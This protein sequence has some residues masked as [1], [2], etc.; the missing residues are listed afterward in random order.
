M[1]WMRFC[2]AGMLVWLVSLSTSVTC[3]ADRPHILWLTAEDMSPTLGCWGDSFADTPNLDKFAE[4]SVTYTHA[5]ATAP[6]CSPARSCLITGV[7]ASSLGTQNLRSAFPLPAAISGF[8][9]HLRKLGYYT[10]NNVKTDYN[11]RDEAELIRACWDES[12]PQAH[13]RKRPGDAPFFSIFNDMTTHQSRSMVWTREHFEQD[14]QSQLQ[15]GRVHDPGRVPLPPYYPDTPVVRRTLARFYDC[16]SV[17]D[18]NVGQRL[19]ELEE[20]G[21]ADETIVFFY[22]D[23]GSGMPRHKRLLLDS[24]MHVP[25]MIRFPKKYQHLAPAAAGEKINRLVSFVDFAPT[26]LSLLGIEPPKHMQ[27]TPFL[28]RFSGRERAYVFGARDRVDEAYD[29]AR[30]ARDHRYLYIRNYLPHESYNQPSAYSDLGE[31]RDDITRLAK[32]GELTGAQWHYACPRRAMEELYDTQNDPQNLVNLASSTEHRDILARMREAQRKWSLKTR[33]LGFAPEIDVQA[34]SQ[35][36]TPY[37]IAR[38]SKRYPLQRIRAT[39][40]LVGRANSETKLRERLQD[41]HPIVR[42]WATVGLRAAETDTAVFTPLLRDESPAVK[43]EA[44]GGLLERGESADAVG[45][46]TKAL[47]ARDL[48]TVLK[49]ARTVQRLGDRVPAALP[50]MRAAQ[51]R[52]AADQSAD[53]LNLFIDFAV[54]MHLVD[55]GEVSQDEVFQ[56][57]R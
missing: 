50:A 17:M 16:V 4:E 22:S 9:T 30:S 2:G 19:R 49:A 40:D 20:D 5:F 34:M 10:S 52:A 25:L 37:E 33:D 51:K 45:V 11:V 53:P 21:L 12:S 23:H 28:G 14:V 38:E 55:L 6:V 47:E 46:L 26:V 31:I 48:H 57:F 29:M 13:W 35:G 18:Q 44:A 56:S 27:G 39:A 15:S 54:T 7:Y 42:F 43:I 1:W 3:G 32:A 36:T 41:P 24:G 8:P